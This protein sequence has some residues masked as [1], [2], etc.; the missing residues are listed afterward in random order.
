[1]GPLVTIKFWFQ[2]F[3]ALERFKF[4][5]EFRYWYQNH[6]DNLHLQASSLMVEFD[7]HVILLY[8][9]LMNKDNYY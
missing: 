3:L 1:M 5:I 2:K 9:L 6:S 4:H 8:A 7:L